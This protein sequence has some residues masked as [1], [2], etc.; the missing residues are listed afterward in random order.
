LKKECKKLNRIFEELLDEFDD[1][2]PDSEW[3]S[4]MSSKTIQR[5]LK[6]SFKNLNIDSKVLE[7]LDS[8]NEKF[9]KNLTDLLNNGIEV[10]EN[11]W[12][13]TFMKKSAGGDDDQKNALDKNN[14]KGKLLT[15]FS[16]FSLGKRAKKAKGEHPVIQFVVDFKKAL[17]DKKI[18]IKATQPQKNVFKM[19][20]Q[21]YDEKF[22]TDALNK[23]NIAE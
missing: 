18:V 14:L 23:L 9:M 1:D 21:S 2:S 19:F 10:L 16:E 22:E 7:L 17:D 11:G 6:N 8:H 12:S 3:D 20:T 13:D 4:K 5:Q 15:E